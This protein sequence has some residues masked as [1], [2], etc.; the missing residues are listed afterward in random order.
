MLAHRLVLEN[1]R[2]YTAQELEFCPGVNIIYGDNAQGK[3]NILEAVYLFSMGKGFRAKKDAELVQH[4]REEARAALTFSD[5]GRDWE[6]EIR[7]FRSRRKA[8][9]VNEVPIRLT[10]EL[11]G[12]FRVIYFGPEYLGLIKEGPRQRR[13]NTDILISQLRPR[14]FS[15]L[16]DVKKII[17]SK[18]ALLK[19]ER[20]NKAMLEILNEKLASISGELIAWRSQYIQKLNQYAAA[21]QNEISGGS[22]TLSM[23]YLSCIG[24]ADGLSAEEITQKL[25]QRLENV[26][27]RELENRETAVGPHREDIAYLIN[28]REAKSFA[29][30]G[31]QKTIVLSQKLSEVALMREE[32]GE[33]PVLLLDDIM[34]ELDRKRQSFVLSHIRDM[35]IFITCT[36]TEGFAL[37]EDTRLLKVE[38]GTVKIVS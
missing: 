21:L 31:Q 22:E 37:R 7:L 32:T 34:S 3:T 15:A 20:P 30:Q 36:D 17:D 14:Y 26:E 4:G 27:R 1:F 18:N 28:G 16:S 9:S 24:A 2:N 25:R 33:A 11:I 6:A 8:I 5:A 35:Q 29:S 19:M 10:S 12:R 13:R 38:N 23:E